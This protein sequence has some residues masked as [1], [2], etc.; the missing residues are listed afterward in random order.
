MNSVA[1]TV[2]VA[3]LTFASGLIGFWIQSFVP[4]PYL[5]DAKGM[6][7]SVVGLVT[8]LLAL[9]LGL[10]VWTSYGVYTVQVSESQ[11]LGPIVLQLDFALERYGTAARRGRE[12][13]HDI[14]LRSRERFWGSGRGGP[15]YPQARKDLGALAEFFAILDPVSEEQKQ[16][17]G[18]A[19]G[20]FIQIIQT[21]LLMARQLD[22]PVPIALLIVVV[23]W[24]A[25]IFFCFGLLNAFNA[26]SVMAEALGSIAVASAMF[27]ILE[28]S[29]PYTGFFRI[30]PVGVDGL[31]RAI[32]ASSRGDSASGD[33]TASTTSES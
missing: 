33:R 8:L 9:V 30:S 13:L 25:L 23:G 27:V 31:I 21:T 18:A 14:V 19:R 32:G 7:G 24:S 15:V 6:V 20:F 17:V 4:Q 12:L 1:R 2:I 5:A 3:L 16:L 22:N 11:S 29:Q 10:L 28:F 26:V